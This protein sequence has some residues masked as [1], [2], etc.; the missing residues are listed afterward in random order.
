MASSRDVP[1][2]AQ[3][4]LIPQVPRTGPAEQ[5]QKPRR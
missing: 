1:H 5:T 4:A 3:E 2:V